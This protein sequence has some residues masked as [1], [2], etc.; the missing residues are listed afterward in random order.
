[1]VHTQ[2]RG[3]VCAGCV[4]NGSRYDSGRY[5]AG[6][7]RRAVGWT[8]ETEVRFDSAHVSGQLPELEDE[9]ESKSQDAAI[10]D[11]TGELEEL[12]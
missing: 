12:H 6:G 2:E 10:E 1:M 7:N 4:F 11:E 5:R 9:A 8:I 3:K